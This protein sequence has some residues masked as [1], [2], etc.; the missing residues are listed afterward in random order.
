MTVALYNAERVMAILCA[1][2]YITINSATTIVELLT[3]IVT[4]NR[5]KIQ[6]G[7]FHGRIM[8]YVIIKIAVQIA[9]DMHK[10]TAL[11]EILVTRVTLVTIT[12]VSVRLGHLMSGSML[13]FL[14]FVGVCM[15]LF[16]KTVLSKTG[17]AFKNSKL[18]RSFKDVDIYW[19]CAVTK[20]RFT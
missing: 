4:L 11:V 5:Q 19:A 6:A 17:G 8:Y 20:T 1:A 3:K 15:F 14:V 18:L 16:A 13:V 12:Y 10:V 7:L 2:V 9:E